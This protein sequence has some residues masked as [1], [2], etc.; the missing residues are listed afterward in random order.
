MRDATLSEVFGA[1]F[2]PIA[3]RNLFLIMTIFVLRCT[4]HQRAMMETAVRR[5]SRKYPL[6]TPRIVNKVRN[7]THDS[8]AQRD[9]KSRNDGDDGGGQRECLKSR[10]IQFHRRPLMQNR[11]TSARADPA[12]EATV[13]VPRGPYQ[14]KKITLTFRRNGGTGGS[15]RSRIFRLN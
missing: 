12:A 11:R 13:C 9:E 10:F 7:H 8:S 2:N 14:D 1:L 5:N 3:R 4:F 6:I 15:F